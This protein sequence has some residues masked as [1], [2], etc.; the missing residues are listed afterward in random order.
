MHRRRR[1]L[2]QPLLQHVLHAGS[3]PGFVP[4]AIERPGQE[5]YPA[6]VTRLAATA[7][8]RRAAFD[9]RTVSSWLAR[10]VADALGAGPSSGDQGRCLRCGWV[11]EA[12]T[13][14]AWQWHLAARRPCPRCV[15]PW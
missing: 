14:K 6:H 11:I 10:L 12:W 9:G 3:R 5:P 4:G 15:R 8:A 1:G 2:P 7:D 13:S